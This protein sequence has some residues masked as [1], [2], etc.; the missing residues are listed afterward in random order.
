MDT[1]SKPLQPTRVKSRDFR[2][3]LARQERERVRLLEQSRA[4]PPT[5][6]PKGTHLRA[7]HVPRSEDNAK[8][9]WREYEEM[10][11]EL[12]DRWSQT[13]HPTPD[14]TARGTSSRRGSVSGHSSY[15]LGSASIPSASLHHRGSS[16]SI[17]SLSFSTSPPSSFPSTPATSA[18]TSPMPSPIHSFSSTHARPF[19]AYPSASTCFKSSPFGA[20]PETAMGSHHRS[21]SYTNLPAP[22]FAVPKRTT[23]SDSDIPQRSHPLAEEERQRREADDAR[24]KAQATE[25][26]QQRQREESSWRATHAQHG[27][28]SHESNRYERAHRHKPTTTYSGQEQENSASSSHRRKEPMFTLDQPDHQRTLSKQSQKVLIRQAWESYETRWATLQDTKDSLGSLNFS[29]IPWP[30]I[31][32]PSSPASL[33]ADS[34]EK[35]LMSTAHSKDKGAKQR[36]R[37]AMLRFHPDR[38]EGRWMNSIRTSDRPAVKEAVGL[39]VR[40]LNDASAKFP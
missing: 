37:D 3:E 36:I 35:F 15:P 9:R 30:V 33:T 22:Q 39:V 18:R 31:N 17:P 24:R 38:F 32:K 26:L 5:Q 2:E 12:L 23:A 13:T 4:K 7:E 27:A 14:P 19:Q 34:I 16:A 1:R 8:M 6:M 11:Y 20:Q 10:Q 40:Y 25:Y 28:T 21:R 29:D